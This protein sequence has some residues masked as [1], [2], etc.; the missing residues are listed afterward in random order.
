MAV[1]YDTT[2]LKSGSHRTHIQSTYTL[3]SLNVSYNLFTLFK[4]LGSIF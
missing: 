1:P 2:K 3:S 4:T